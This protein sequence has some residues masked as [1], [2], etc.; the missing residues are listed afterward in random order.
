QNPLSQW[1]V[2]RDGGGERHGVELRVRQQLVELGGEVSSGM[3]AL[4]L[5]PAGLV[6]VTAPD[7]L[8]PLERAQVAG[9]VGPPVAEADYSHTDRHGGGSVEARAG[10]VAPSVRVGFRPC[11]RSSSRPVAEAHRVQEAANA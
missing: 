2:G 10:E 11:K 4:P 1:S 7:Q 3:Q 5:A 8:A 9:Q 6:G